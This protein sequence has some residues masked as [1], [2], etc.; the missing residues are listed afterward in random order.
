MKTLVVAA[1]LEA[2][3]AVL[4]LDEFASFS[5]TDRET[6]ARIARLAGVK[7]R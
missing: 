7:P 3:S 2:G 6:Y 4:S 5:T 1:L